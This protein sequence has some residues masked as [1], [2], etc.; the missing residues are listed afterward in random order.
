MTKKWFTLFAI[1]MAAFVLFVG[2]KKEKTEETPISTPEAC[3]G[4]LHFNSLEEFRET[5]EKV[6][7]MS[8]TERRE[9]E[10]QQ[11]FKSYATKCEELFEELE[12]KGINSDEDIYNFIKENSDYFYIREEEGEKYLTSYLEFSSYYQFVDENRMVRIG[13]NVIKVFDEGVICA[14]T[15]KGEELLNVTTFYEPARD[16]FFYYENTQ[17]E[18]LEESKDNED[19][20]NCGRQ[21]TIVRKT[22]VNG[23]ERTY[24][25]F[26][27]E[28]KS[29]ST[30][31]SGLDEYYYLLGYRNV[32][33]RMKVRPYRK[34]FGIWFWCQRTISYNVNYS[35]FDNFLCQVVSDNKQGQ[36][37]GGK[38][39]IILYS[40]QGYPTTEYYSSI[41]GH[42]STPDASCII[43]CSTIN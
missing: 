34:N 39:D 4:I 38:I 41:T 16:G 30:G 42:A 19:G 32:N 3:L 23:Y 8:E 9:W 15:N 18:F 27:I 24:A 5:Q 36:D 10:R 1:V 26:Y 14:P 28:N 13:S 12:A 2:C 43:T 21:E 37:G 35:V 7:A 11:G 6:L 29:I 31:N 40:F 20:C 17:S 22:N 33:Y 25:R